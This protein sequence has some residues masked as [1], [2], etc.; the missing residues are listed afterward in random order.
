[1]CVSVSCAGWVWLGLCVVQ[2]VSCVSEWV[3]VRRVCGAGSVCVRVRVCVCVFVCCACM[4]AC[5][6]FGLGS[7]SVF[8]LIFRPGLDFL[9]LSVFFL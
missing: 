2:V 7:L 8:G 6:V 3:V 4:Y 1:M 9:L 5:V